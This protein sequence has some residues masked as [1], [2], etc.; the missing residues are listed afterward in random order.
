MYL[1]S[2]I[3]S[4]VCSEFNTLTE[5]TTIGAVAIVQNNYLFNRDAND[6]W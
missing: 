1:M 6:L 4:I 2:L 3:L 5:I